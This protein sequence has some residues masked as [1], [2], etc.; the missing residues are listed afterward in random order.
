LHAL[1]DEDRLSTLDALNDCPGALPVR[2][3]VLFARDSQMTAGKP[4]Y[5]TGA[6]SMV[7]A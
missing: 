4:I 1:S 7:Q 5:Q 6:G 3:T 2:V